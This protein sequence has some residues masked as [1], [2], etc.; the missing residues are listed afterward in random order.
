MTYR[1]YSEFFY[2]I[3][4]FLFQVQFT[5]LYLPSASLLPVSI[6]DIRYVWKVDDIMISFLPKRAEFPSSIHASVPFLRKKGK[7][8]TL[9]TFERNLSISQVVIISHLLVLNLVHRQLKTDRYFQ[10]NYKLQ[11]LVIA[12]YTNHCFQPRKIIVFEKIK[13]FY[14]RF[15][16]LNVLGWS[17]LTL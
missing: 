4:Y 6:D 1:K 10:R 7:V 9:F 2:F 3:F 13:N 12:F 16:A 8:L 14:K 15:Y 5:I 17:R 11:L